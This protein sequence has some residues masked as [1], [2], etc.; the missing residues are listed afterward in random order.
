MERNQRR[1]PGRRPPRWRRLLRWAAG[2]VA[3]LLG[4][5]LATVAWLSRD[6]PSTT[7]LQVITQSVK[8][9]V[10]DKDGEVYGSYGIE[11]RL[12]IPLAQVPR[13]LVDAVLSVEDRRFYDHWGIDLLRWP[14]VIL[15]DIRIRLRSRSAPLHGASTLTQQL[16]R[17]LFLTKDQSLRRKIKEAILT[18]KIERTYSKDEIL[19]MYLNQIYFGVGAYGVESI[20]QALFGKPA[21]ELD[22]VEAAL[23]AGLPKNPW[24]YD[25]FRFPE[26]ARQ[27]RNIA[28]A[29]MRDNGVL[30]EAACDSL[31]ALPLTLRDRKREQARSGSYFLEHVRRYLETRYGTE[32][33]Y[34]DGLRV[35]T[36]I[37]P[38]AQLAAEEQLEAHLRY[39]EERMGYDNTYESVT[40]RI[41]SGLAISASEQYLQGSVVLLDVPTGAVRALV[42]GRDFRHSEYNRAVQDGRPSGSAFKI[43][44]Y[45]AAIE[46]GF[47][48]S[49]HILDTPVVIEIP[50][51]PAYKPRNHSGR[52]LGEISL[53]YALNKSINIP[54]VK[55][56]QRMGPMT[57]INYARRLGIE[58]PLP[59]VL[60]I[61][62]GS[63]NV[64]PLEMTSAYATVAAGGIRTRPYFIARVVDRWGQ[65]LEQHQ[66]ERVE[67]LDA[68]SNY[69]L[70]NM[71]E[72]VISDGT[73]VRARRMGFTHPAAGKT[74]TTDDNYDAWFVGFTRYYACGV[75]VGFDER[76]SMG[77][78]ME[79][80]HAALPIWAGIM[81]EIHTD[82][83]PLP[84]EQP[85]GVITLSVCKDSGL[86]PTQYCPEVVQEVFI[87]GKQPTRPCD[88]HAPS[89]ASLLGTS[90]DFRELD[91]QTRDEEELPTP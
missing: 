53:R 47:A 68:K 11:N 46:N 58:S 63:E 88:R 50:G 2:V 16:A 81:K 61:S 3:F 41:D 70:A 27:R 37:D 24:A 6:L 87:E 26:R 49:D 30:D 23:V 79:G 42:G 75:W 13:H 48:P 80:A 72:S 20:S 65:V 74:G 36:T 45:L 17:D 29:M 91:R 35:F 34:R 31:Q 28:L 8:T 69:I 90:V 73:G 60:A 19:A 59:N 84:F 82:L 85:E 86:L 32:R 22:V 43:F 33:L 71:L 52:F 51:H 25:P 15:T 1:L 10:L 44:V 77:R 7:R 57:V 9:L 78:W 67:V 21:A 18:L 64:T 39:C 40:A 76:L 14:K 5:G 54:A 62:L 56:T 89:E 38:A 4:M 66:P 12:P 55:L 83:A